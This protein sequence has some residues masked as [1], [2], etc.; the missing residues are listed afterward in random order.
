MERLSKFKAGLIN[1]QFPLLQPKIVKKML[2]TLLSRHFLRYLVIGF[3]TFFMQIALLYLFTN[4]FSFDKIPGNICSTLLSMVFNFTMSNYWTFKAGSEKQ[5]RKLGRYAVVAAGN[6]VFDTLLAF[7]ILAV[8]LGINQ[9]V[10]KIL[11]TAMIVSWNFFI[12]KFWVFKT[13]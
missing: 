6:Y 11:I 2:E 1:S 4:V 13:S 3:T 12:Y 7:P 9:Y 10:A 5:A 8:S